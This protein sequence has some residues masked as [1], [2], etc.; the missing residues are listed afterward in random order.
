MAVN[1]ALKHRL[2]LDKDHQVIKFQK[3]EK[4][5]F[6]LMSNSLLGKTMENIRKH[7]DINLVMNEEMYL[8]RVMKPN[9]KS[10]IIFSKNLMGS[11]MGK[12]QVTMN[13]PVYLGQ[14]I[15]GLSKIIMYEFHYD[16][17]K[18]KYG[19]NLQ[20]CYMD[21][22]SLVYDIKMIFT[23]TSPAMLRLCLTQVATA[24]VGFVLSP[25]ELTRRSLAL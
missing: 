16:Y 15:L 24:A 19:K 11:E 25:C 22:D 20:L 14:S 18:P 4:D 2:V 3:F 10:G 6:K 12:I 21:T 23:K 1:Q 5:F 7:R 13:K 9:L 17:I 8:K